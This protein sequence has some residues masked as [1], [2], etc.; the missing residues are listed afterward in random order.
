MRSA[1][2]VS[3]IYR[4]SRRLRLPDI[5][6]SEDVADKRHP[7]RLGFGAADGIELAEDDQAPALAIFHQRAVL[8]AVAAVEDRAEVAARGF[9]DQGGG[10]IA[11]ISTSPDVRQLDA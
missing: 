9:F 4:A 10:D 7:R 1:G 11:A 5:D 2:G 6:V 3:Q 8:Q